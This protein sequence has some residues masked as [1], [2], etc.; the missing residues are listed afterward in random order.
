MKEKDK[1]I[2][3][4]RTRMEDC[5]EPVPAGL[6]EQLE[7]ELDATP[8][9]IPMW[10]RWQAVAAV[11]LLVLVSSLTVWFWQSPSA[12]YL[13]QQSAELD[14]LHEPDGWRESAVV[15]EPPMARIAHR[16]AGQLAAGSPS[17]ALKKAV[18][19]REDLA[20]KEAEEIQTE[21]NY[22]EEQAEAPDVTERMRRKKTGRS[23]YHQAQKSEYAYA[24]SGRK[25]ERNWSIGLSTGNGTFSSSARMDGYLPLPNAPRS[26]SMLANAYGVET[27]GG[28]ENL[29]QFNNLSE[30]QRAQSD[31]KY[32]MPVTFGASLRFDLSKEWALETGV[33]YTQLSSEIRS[34]TEKNNYGWEEKLH[35]V[36]IPL[37]VNR[38]V[39]SNKRLEVYASA[40][41]AVEKCVAGKRSV[42]GSVSTFGED[43]NEQIQQRE[44]T[45]KVEPLQWS[46]SAAAGAQ[47]KVTE[48]WGIY[49]EPGVVYYFDD[50]SK[51]N[52]V[53]KEHPLNFNLQLGMRFS[54]L[55]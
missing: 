48:K 6:W 17:V 5:S 42:M 2:Q 29:V 10:R 37:K 50:G 40:G 15:P 45:L 27:R 51:V 3:N 46:L 4:F 52:T 21:E 55:K 25:R 31:I 7:K 13:V 30:Q 19:A 1:W 36:G 22:P 14:S 24:A 32:R 11:A 23:S 16:A 54:L 34:G 12:D 53:R 35:Y 44:E 8:K 9:A 18:V 43:R 47:F 26:S 39:W 28:I 20:G 38:S 49:V 41:G 33:M